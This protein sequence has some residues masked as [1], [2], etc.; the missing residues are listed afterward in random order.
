MVDKIGSGY[1]LNVK[2]PFLNLDVVDEISSGW[3]VFRNWLLSC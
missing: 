3:V 1:C 2:L